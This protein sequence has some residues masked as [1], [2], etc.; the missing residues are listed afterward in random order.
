MLCIRACLAMILAATLVSTV[1]GAQRAQPSALT[2]VR[3]EA[4]ARWNVGSTASD[5]SPSVAAT[6]RAQ[7]RRSSAARYAAVGAMSGLVAAT[8]FLVVAGLEYGTG[9][10][11]LPPVIIGVVTVGG[12]TV[13]A[14]GGLAVYGVIRIARR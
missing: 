13:G 1:A 2:A 5:S 11:S 8:V 7:K 14:V 4:K 3:S 10:A 9:Y 12:A 6:L